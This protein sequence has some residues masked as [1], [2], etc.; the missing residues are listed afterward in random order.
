MRSSND[1]IYFVERI[2]R[3]PE[4]KNEVLFWKIPEVQK[5]SNI[6]E[7]DGWED[8]EF[9][10]KSVPDELIFDYKSPL[11]NSIREGSFI[12]AN[13]S[14]S[15]L[16]F[17]NANGDNIARRQIIYNNLLRSLGIKKYL[18][19]QNDGIKFINPLT[20]DEVYSYH[21]YVGHGN[22]SLVVYKIKGKVYI[23]MIDCSVY[24]FLQKRNYSS[25]L[26]SCID[27][28]KEKFQ[29]EEF[30][31][32]YFFLT[33]PHFD[34]FNGIK[35]LINHS[36]LNNTELWMNLYFSWPQPQYNEIL[37]LLN[38]NGNLF[39]EPIISNSQKNISILY[40]K[41]NIERQSKIK[42]SG[43]KINNSS[44]VYHFGFNKKSIVFPGDLE[45]EGWDETIECYPY[46]KECSYYCISHHGSLNGHRR[47][48]CQ[49]GES[50][51]T[52]KHCIPNV[53]YALLMGRDN[54]FSGIYNPKVISDFGSKLIK[55]EALK[56]NELNNFVELN[57][58]N[59]NRTKY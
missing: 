8:I 18:G 56:G 16:F 40:P 31:I 2:E 43:K 4:E 58:Q 35:Y 59:D 49:M 11:K 9:I 50:I 30:H 33:H 42:P 7:D 34:H 5:D 46:L 27:F 21:V 22:C 23:W 1:N 38:N 15:S 57:W 24:D 41:D 44:T 10:T 39:R 48:I 47:N 3:T 26:K 29:L 45:T 6:S 20:V 54:A 17:N 55:I 12:Y 32:D 53:K 52:I 37:A 51:S 25:N 36:Y 19:T 13:D 14:K 28:I